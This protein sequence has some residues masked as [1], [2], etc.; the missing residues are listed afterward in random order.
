MVLRGSYSLKT[1]EEAHRLGNLLKAMVDLPT[2]FKGNLSLLEIFSAGGVSKWKWFSRAWANRRVH[3]TEGEGQD[4]LVQPTWDIL[5]S[6]GSVEF[7][8]KYQPQIHKPLC[9]RGLFNAGS[10]LADVVS[11]CLPAIWFL[12]FLDPV[13]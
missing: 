5:D 8:G 2:W 12:S 6:C 9:I 11:W 4:Q 10:T 7:L 13:I 1:T 3:G